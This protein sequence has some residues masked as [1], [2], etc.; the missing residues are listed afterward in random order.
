MPAYEEV[1]NKSMFNLPAVGPVGTYSAES[2]VMPV[3][4][5]RISFCVRAV[6]TKRLCL[7]VSQA[8][9]YPSGYFLIA[10]LCRFLARV[11]GLTNPFQNFRTGLY[12]CC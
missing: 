5:K 6:P 11:C 9:Y 4:T 7:D 3:I 10:L 1:F 12:M 2:N 8:H